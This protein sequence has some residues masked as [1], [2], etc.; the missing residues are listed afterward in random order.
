MPTNKTLNSH[1]T[2]NANLVEIKTIHI[3]TCPI[4]LNV[5]DQTSNINLKY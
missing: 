2:K 3:V 4:I 5:S 1:N